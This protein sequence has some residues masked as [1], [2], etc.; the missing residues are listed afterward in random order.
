MPLLQSN[1]ADE[2][3]HFMQTPTELLNYFNQSCHLSNEFI[4]QLTQ[5]C[6]FYS[7]IKIKMIINIKWKI[8]HDKKL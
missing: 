7:E 5:E 2:K 3:C 4:S 6:K 1:S 8:E